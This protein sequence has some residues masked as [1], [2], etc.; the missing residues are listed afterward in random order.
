MGRKVFI[1]FLG[2]SSYLNCNYCLSD[3]E[4]IENVEFV[5]EA[6]IKI[7]FKNVNENNHIYIFTTKKAKDNNYENKLKIILENLKK[8]NEYKNINFSNIMIPEGK[9]E[10]QIMEIFENV[11]N[12]FEENDEIIYDITHSFRSLPM[13]GITVLFYA[14]FLKNIKIDGIYYGAFEVLG[15]PKDVPK[16]PIEKRNAPIFNLTSFANIIDWSFGV[17]FFIKYGNSDYISEIINDF[18][19]TLNT[20]NIIS[21]KNERRELNAIF[22]EI[23]NKVNEF[24]QNILACRGEKINKEFDY[25]YFNEL[26][27]KIE[28]LSNNFI[29][30]M[31]PLI[32][33]MNNKI[34][35]YKKN[36]ILNGFRAVEWCVEHG[37]I[38]Q[39]ITLLQ[40]NIITYFIEK[41]NLINKLD[42]KNDQE[43]TELRLNVSSIIHFIVKNGFS[44]EQI[45]NNYKE[46][47]ELKLMDKFKAYFLIILKE[48]IIE[49]N[50]KIAV[51]FEKVRDYRNNINHGGFI[52]GDIDYN[53]FYNTLKTSIKELKE[54]L[55]F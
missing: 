10:K 48:I 46:Y 9:S 37:L 23:K 41:Y 47:N 31:V 19:K 35:E 52:R 50:K 42:I 26:L 21:N 32:G 11:Y 13:L 49:E 7:F 40:E 6:L 28:K 29:K 5:Q 3:N 25:E 44:I 2:T 30:P 4:K 18:K 12:S 53:R 54:I 51:F 20:K 45:I 24:S 33:K 38:Q 36:D 43:L 8:E 22:N 55:K 15:N 34:I 16:I 17:S 14:K 27:K 39:G 1:S